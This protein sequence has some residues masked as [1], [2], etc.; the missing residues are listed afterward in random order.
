M[1]VCTPTRSS[2]QS[3]RLPVHVTT[4]L[5]NPDV[6]TAGIPAEMTGMAEVLRRAGYSTH[7]TGKWDAVSPP[8]THT[9]TVTL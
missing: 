7:F 4:A 5:S 9:S 8:N 3:G 2:I 6:P 1:Q